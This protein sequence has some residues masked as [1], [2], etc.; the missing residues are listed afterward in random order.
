MSAQFAAI[1]SISIS[2]VSAD[3]SQPSWEF[4]QYLFS[5]LFPIVHWIIAYLVR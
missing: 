4:L 2:A 3:E 5:S 1:D